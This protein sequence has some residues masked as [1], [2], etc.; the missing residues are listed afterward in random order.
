ME[1]LLLNTNN[2]TSY[3]LLNSVGQLVF[4][5]FILIIMLYIFYYIM[6]IIKNIKHNNFP[7]KNIEIVERQYLNNSCSMII[8]K[9]GGKFL[10]LSLS[11]EKVNFIKE[12]V[13]E[14][15][16]INDINNSVNYNFKDIISKKMKKNREA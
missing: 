7:L 9:V 10:L 4:L 16:I 1:V 3:N 13:K 6:K 11:K 14:D 12:L 8:A 2:K 15:L 5:M